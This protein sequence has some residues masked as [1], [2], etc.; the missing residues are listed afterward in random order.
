MKGTKDFY[1]KTAPE[2]ANKWYED[3]SLL[4]YLKEFINYL[5]KKPRILDLCCGAGYESMRMKKL[6]ADVT[7]LDFSEESI[8]IAKER[9]SD[10]KFVVE[11]MLN[12][13][14]YLG[15]FDGCA[16][17]AG[18]VH[19]PN[20]KLSR[21]FEQIHKI[22]DNGGFLFIAVKDGVGKNEKSSYTTIDTEQY[23]RDFYMHTLEELK[24]YSST[25]FDFVK[26]LLFEESSPWKYYIFK[27][28]MT[29]N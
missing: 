26:E 6:G 7:G 27:K 17:I 18:L 23:D 12:D 29:D 21:E 9:N 10:I 19:L 20:E 15:K 8:K 13:Y 22:L 25:K 11:D 16:V 3:E 1:N 4:P 5:P 24:L 28:C 2:W 14:S